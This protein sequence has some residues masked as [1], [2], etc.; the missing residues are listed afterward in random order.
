VN[1]NK[2]KLYI[3]L[4]ALDAIYNFVVDFF[5]SK[6]FFVPKCN[7]KIKI[8]KYINMQ[9]YFGTLNSF[10]SKTF[11]LQSCRSRRGLQF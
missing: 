3:K 7:F 8:S 5:Y 11:Q 2:D 10:N 1:S 9:Q 6:S 4:V